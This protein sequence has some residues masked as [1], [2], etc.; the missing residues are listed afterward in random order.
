MLASGAQPGNQNAKKARKWRESLERA[1]ARFGS[2]VDLGL[3]KI[4]DKVVAAAAD[5][6]KDAWQEI[7]C[8]IDG[9]VPQGIIGGDDDDPAIKLH[10]MVELVK[11]SE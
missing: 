10:A 4:A 9:K 5:G 1:L 8:R 11:P 6:D 7:A 2:S 3:D